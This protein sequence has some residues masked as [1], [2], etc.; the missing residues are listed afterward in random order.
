MST[1]AKVAW[2]GAILLLIPVLVSPAGWMI[3]VGLA[4][5]WL[6]LTLVGPELWEMEKS[7]REGER[8]MIK[9]VRRRSRGGRDE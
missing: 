8:G 3:G 2:G 1:K 4:V 5:G 7:R 9:D 6:L